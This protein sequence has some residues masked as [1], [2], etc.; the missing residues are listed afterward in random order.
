MLLLMHQRRS[1]NFTT[2][3]VDGSHLHWQTWRIFYLTI[4]GRFTGVLLIVSFLKPSSVTI[5]TMLPILAGLFSSMTIFPTCTWFIK[6]LWWEP[7]CLPLPQWVSFKWKYWT[8]S[9]VCYVQTVIHL[10]QNVLFSLLGYS[11]GSRSYTRSDRWCSL[12]V[13][14]GGL[15]RSGSFLHAR[16][17]PL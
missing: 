15:Y 11:D 14:A 8:I 12:L 10:T 3:D 9:L 4:T 7:V 2:R 5:I 6:P 17:L 13:V 16:V 1:G